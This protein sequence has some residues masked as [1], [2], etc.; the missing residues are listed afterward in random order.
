MHVSGG[1]LTGLNQMTPVVMGEYIMIVFYTN[2]AAP[3]A[4]AGHGHD[5]REIDVK[6]LAV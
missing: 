4:G 6:M 1:N 2:S 3:K 5:D